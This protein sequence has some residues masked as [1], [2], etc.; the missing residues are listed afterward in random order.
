MDAVLRAAGVYFFLL[1]LMRLSG[2][3]TLAQVTPFDFVPWL[4][5]GEATDKAS[6]PWARRRRSRGSFA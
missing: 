6:W 5:I 2:K 3:R 4:I 1:L